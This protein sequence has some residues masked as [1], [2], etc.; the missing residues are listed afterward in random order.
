VLASHDRRFLFIHVQK[1]GGTTVEHLLK[2]AVPDVGKPEG[3][4]KHA[5][6]RSALRKHPHVAGYWTFGFVRN[7]WARYV[8]WWSMIQKVSLPESKA[9]WSRNSQF[10]QGTAKYPSFEAFVERGPEDFSRLSRPQ[11]SYL[12]T[13]TRK[14]DFIGRTETF[15][16]DMR[17]V[18]ARLDLSLP[19]ELPQRNRSTHGSY[20]DYY[21]PA[22][23]DRIGELFKA[24][25]DA[26]LYDF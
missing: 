23:R 18:L 16:E 14:A 17:A 7:P 1:T 6:L 10:V 2:K 3:C 13:T 19:E 24:D 12:T 9:S 21:T 5:G 22:T 25:I 4:R 26:F 11:I 15:A 8:S 20:R